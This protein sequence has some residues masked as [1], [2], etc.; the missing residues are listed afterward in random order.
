MHALAA[1]YPNVAQRL[2]GLERA[3]HSM[4]TIAVK[5]TWVRDMPATVL[6][7][8]PRP[9]PAAD[10]LWTGGYLLRHS[11]YVRM[12]VFPAY[13]VSDG[14]TTASA[15]VFGVTPTRAPVLG[16]PQTS[17]LQLLVDVDVPV[18]LDLTDGGIRKRLRVTRAEI[19]KTPDLTVLDAWMRPLEYELPQMIGELA[20]LAGYGGVKYPAARATAGSNLVV[21]TG[22]LPKVSGTISTTNPFTGTRHQLP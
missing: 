15:E 13:H 6:R 20:Y 1:F 5:G 21:F 3:V 12:G 22:N 9:A 11:R 7:A 8:R 16:V 2:G 17:R 18:V 10:P 4:P 14:V 19:V